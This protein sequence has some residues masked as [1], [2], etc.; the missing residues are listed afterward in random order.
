MSRSSRAWATPS[1]SP[2]A[3]GP[4]MAAS[5]PT[6]CGGRFPGP[7]MSGSS[8]C[9][10]TASRFRWCTPDYLEGEAV[11]SPDGRSIAYTTDDSG[12]PNVFVQSF[13]RGRRETSGVDGRRERPDLAIGWQ[14]AVLP[15][16]RLDLDGRADR[17]DR[18]S[19]CRVRRRRS[20]RPACSTPA[21]PSARRL[22]LGQLLRR[23]ERRTA[24]PYQREDAAVRQR[25]APERRRQLD[26][27]DPDDNHGP[28][29]RHPA[30][31]RPR[32]PR[33]C[34]P[35]LLACTRLARRHAGRAG[36]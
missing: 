5:S 25:A 22:P 30:N 21:S 28:D 31:R 34:R 23:V 19:R 24:L 12:Q 36:G 4:R 8:P 1:G 6:R 29:A 11:F 17:H 3:A 32:P 9:S 13:P 16:P 15:R 2:R 33:R 7:P 20:F 26:G 14:G 35:R 18:P 27:R 10:A